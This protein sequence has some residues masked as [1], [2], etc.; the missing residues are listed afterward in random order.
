MVSSVTRAS[1]RS[2][3][4]GCATCWTPADRR[5]P[6]QRTG[7][8]ATGTLSSTLPLAAGGGAAL[9]AAGAGILVLR[10]RRK[11]A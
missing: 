5:G 9:L 7:L 8:G 10:R 2:S 1:P 4:Q 11:R 3:R 6:A